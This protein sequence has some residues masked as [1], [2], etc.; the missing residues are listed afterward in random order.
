MF[1]ISDSTGLSLRAEVLGGEFLFSGYVQDKDRMED[2]HDSLIE[3]EIL[4]R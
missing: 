3:L 1:R 2:C 4:S